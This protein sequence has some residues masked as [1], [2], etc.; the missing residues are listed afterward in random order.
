MVRNWIAF[1]G[2]SEGSAVEFAEAVVF[3]WDSG[4]RSALPEIVVA[5]LGATLE[6]LGVRLSSP[7]LIL[8]VSTR[9]GFPLKVPLETG[10]EA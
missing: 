8:L 3:P 2:A 4:H 7:D 6:L 9:L 5:L 10:G 1:G